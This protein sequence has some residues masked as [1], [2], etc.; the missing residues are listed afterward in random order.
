M[1][2]CPILLCILLLT[3]VLTKYNI[4]TCICSAHVSIGMAGFP[5]IPRKRKAQIPRKRGTYYNDCV[6]IIR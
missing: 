1:W 6:Q 3:V 4:S 2:T 5:G